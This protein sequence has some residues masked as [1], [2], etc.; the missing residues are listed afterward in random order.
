MV[1]GRMRTT[2]IYRNVDFS[3]REPSDAIVYERTYRLCTAEFER[4]LKPKRSSYQR[5]TEWFRQKYP[6]KM[7]GKYS[8]R[9]SR[10]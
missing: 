8:P 4:E 1:M 5:K 3:K 7:P 9:M 6:K 2:G 10:S